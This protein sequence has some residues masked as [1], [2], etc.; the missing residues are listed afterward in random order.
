M[1]SD[2]GTSLLQT[3]KIKIS[4]FLFLIITSITPQVIDLVIPESALAYNASKIRRPLIF[5]LRPDSSIPQQQQI[6]TTTYPQDTF[7]MPQ[8]MAPVIDGMNMGNANNVTGYEGSLIK[9]EQ[10][11]NALFFIFRAYFS[12]P[13]DKSA[14]HAFHF[15]GKNKYV[16]DVFG[17]W[18]SEISAHKY[19]YNSIGPVTAVTIGLHPNKVR[20]VF[21]L[22]PYYQGQQIKPLILNDGSRLRILIPQKN[23]TI[24]PAPATTSPVPTPTVGTTTSSTTSSSTTTTPVF[25]EETI[26]EETIEGEAAVDEGGDEEGGDEEYLDEEGGEEEYLDEEGGEE[27][28]LDEEGG[29]EEYLDEEGGEEEY[30][31][32]EGG[33]EELGEEELGDEE[34]GEEELGDE[35]LGEEELGGEE[36]GEE[37]AEEEFDEEATYEGSDDDEG[38]DRFGDRTF[39]DVVDEEEGFENDFSDDTDPNL[40]DPSLL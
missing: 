20:F 6:P 23:L 22:N 25:T 9:V 21:D 31:D 2:F 16:V 36:L 1:K 40:Q 34:L 11:E 8:E 13:V 37:G 33:E 14:V 4:V 29:E 12:K 28:Y 39:E 26:T 15:M 3:L 5:N 7:I 27:E 10:A 18:K 32:E 30:L 35:E 38:S 19:N 17:S 24:A